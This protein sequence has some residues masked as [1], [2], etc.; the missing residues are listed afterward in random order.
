MREPAEAL[1]AVSAVQE[2]YATVE[3]ITKK[4][5]GNPSML[6]DYRELGEEEFLKK[7]LKSETPETPETPVVDT[8]VQTPQEVQETDEVA[9]LKADLEERNRLLKELNEDRFPSLEKRLSSLADENRALQEKLNGTAKQENVFVDEDL[10]AEIKVDDL[11]PESLYDPEKAKTF[12]GSFKGLAG[13]YKKIAAKLKELEGEVVSD[14][15]AKAMNQSVEDERAEIDR[16]R[17]SNPDMFNSKRKIGEIEE[18]YLNFMGGLGRLVG[19]QGVIVDPKTGQFA[20][21]ISAAYQKYHDEKDSAGLKKK[22]DAANIKM[23]EDFDDIVMV[24]KLREIRSQNLE[25]DPTGTIKPWS[26]SKS[27]DYYVAK[28]PLPEDPKLVMARKKKEAEVK[29]IENRAQ[30]AKELPPAGGSN[31]V[32]LNAVTET[33]FWGR[34]E[35]YRK[36]GSEELKTWIETVCKQ[37]GW[38]QAEIDNLIN[39]S[40]PKKG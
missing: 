6:K 28:Q 39:K 5:I 38:E 12:I 37:I 19:Y 27:L 16:L 17:K 31:P 30:F 10:P 24:H 9:R 35:Q 34:V 23:P 11:D 14:K 40:K 26:Y 4:M 8:D 20:P 36:S 25:R 32:D 3:D 22:A 1:G 21:E 15:H 7:Y 2:Q 29:A 33:E 13:A 18:D